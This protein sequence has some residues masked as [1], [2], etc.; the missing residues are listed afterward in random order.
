MATLTAESTA[1]P[2]LTVLKMQG[3][4]GCFS[5][6][7]QFSKLQSWHLS[8]SP[9]DLIFVPIKTM[10]GAVLILFPSLIKPGALFA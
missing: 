1:I 2:R 7:A 6:S 5:R 10:T 3:I 4:L 9:K 8:F